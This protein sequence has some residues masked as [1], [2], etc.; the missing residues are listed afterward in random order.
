MR[1]GLLNAGLGGGG[2]HPW[3]VRVRAGCTVESATVDLGL[4]GDVVHLLSCRRHPIGSGGRW[5]QLDA[6]ALSPIVDRG[7]RL[8]LGDQIGR[9]LRLAQIAQRLNGVLEHMGGA[10]CMRRAQIQQHEDGPAFDEHRHVL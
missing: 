2:G 10:L 3:K 1:L 5:A 6:G 9:L 7:C 8:I 4:N